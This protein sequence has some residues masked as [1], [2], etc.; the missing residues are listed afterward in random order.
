MASGCSNIPL[1]KEVKDSNPAMLLTILNVTGSSCIC[2]LPIK[3]F[4]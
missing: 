2:D 3:I 1:N 4:T